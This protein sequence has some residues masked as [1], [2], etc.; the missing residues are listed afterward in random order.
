MT[1]KNI[2]EGTSYRPISLISVIANS[3]EKPSS[4]HTNQTYQTPTQ[5]GYD[6][7][8]YSD[9]T[10][11]IKQHRSKGVQANGSPCAIN[12]CS[13]RYEQ[14]FRQNRHTHTYQFIANYIKGCK[15]YTTY[16]NHISSQRQFKTGVPQGGV[17]SPT[18]YNIYTADI[19]PPRALVQVIAY[20]DEI[21]S[22]H[23]QERVQPR[24]TYNHIPT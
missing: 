24:N 10:T 2:D 14:S 17:L 23:T 22:T 18:L 19:P 12:H 1:Y 7:Q 6:T 13:T 16:I 9:G 3:R 11:H 8:H 4:L 21:T 20:A 15:A 5:H